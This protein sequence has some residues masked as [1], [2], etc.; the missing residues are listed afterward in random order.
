MYT[1]LFVCLHACHSMDMEIKEQF[2]GIS[3]LIPSCAPG[4]QGQVIRLGPDH[5]YQLH[6]LNGPECK[7]LRQ[8]K[9]FS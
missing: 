2:M 9:Y 6:H 7:L 5:V 1:Y 8:L 4:D 3:P